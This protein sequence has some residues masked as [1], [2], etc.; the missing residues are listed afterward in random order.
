VFKERQV[1]R[2]VPTGD[3]TAPYAPRV[4]SKAVGCLNQRTVAIGEDG[5]GNPAAYF[6]SA[7]GPY[8]FGPNGLQNLTHDVSDYWNTLNVGNDFGVFYQRRRQYWLYIKPSGQ[9]NA[10]RL[11]FHTRLGVATVTGEVVGGW[12]RDSITHAESAVGVISVAHSGLFNSPDLYERPHVLDEDG[13]V[14]AADTDTQDVG[15]SYES[16]VWT[17][18]MAPGGL[19]V[20][21]RTGSPVIVG[22]SPTSSSLA[23]RQYTNYDTSSPRNSTVSLTTTRTH[24]RCDEGGGT[25]DSDAVSFRIGDLG[26]QNAQ[27]TI[28]A[29]VVAWEPCGDVATI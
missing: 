6:A 27:W 5:T 2:L 7:D 22:V 17:A 12:V 21:V 19:A 4:I 29:V 11:R 14:I 1:W 23:V 3:D 28:D 15:V 24:G 9:T 25:N 26:E 16:Y 18:P 8:R 13:N 10:I 20:R